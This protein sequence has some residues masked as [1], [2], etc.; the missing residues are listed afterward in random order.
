VGAGEEQR[1]PD[2]HDDAAGRPLLSLDVAGHQKANPLKVQ[3]WER[4][5]WARKNGVPWDLEIGYVEEI[6]PEDNRCPVASQRLTGRG[7]P[8]VRPSLFSDGA[9]VLIHV[10]DASDELPVRQQAGPDDDSGRGLLL[11]ESL[12]VAWGSELQASGGKIT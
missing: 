3:L 12:S 11:V 4:R 9:R 5:R 8:A 2:L 6:W 7:L 10:W 1:V